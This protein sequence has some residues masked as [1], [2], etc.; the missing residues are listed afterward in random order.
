M[1]PRAFAGRTQEYHRE[2]RDLYGP[3]WPRPLVGEPA[4]RAFHGEKSFA[5]CWE[6][7]T[8]GCLYA[9]GGLTAAPAHTC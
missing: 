8:G 3:W 2:D 9:S 6:N 5:V 1:R 4:F 7:R